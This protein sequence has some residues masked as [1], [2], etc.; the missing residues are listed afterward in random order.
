MVH[1]THDLWNVEQSPDFRFVDSE[2]MFFLVSPWQVDVL[3]PFPFK[4]LKFVL[5]AASGPHDD[6]SNG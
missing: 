2:L 3:S 6:A 4:F 1:Q 5:H